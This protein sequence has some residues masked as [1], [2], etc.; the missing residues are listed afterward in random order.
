[1]GG[2]SARSLQL[3]RPVYSHDTHQIVISSDEGNHFEYATKVKIEN[4]KFH[5]GLQLGMIL[6]W[7]MDN[8]SHQTTTPELLF[9]VQCPVL[10]ICTV[11]T[12]ADPGDHSISAHI[13]YNQFGVEF[14][15]VRSS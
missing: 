6:R 12:L 8:N 4:S 10:C 9:V 11:V 3:T 7:G 13:L 2:M 14:P 15:T 1:M 5:P